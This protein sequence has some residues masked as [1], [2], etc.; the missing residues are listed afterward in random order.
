MVTKEE[1][2]QRKFIDGFNKENTSYKVT[3]AE[4][5][6]FSEKKRKLAMEINKIVLTY[7][8]EH[9]L[10]RNKTYDDIYDK[11]QLSQDI[12]KK[13][14]SGTNRATRQFLY[15]FC[16]GME[17]SR[18]QV[19]ELFALSG[20]GALTDDNIGDYIFVR[21]LGKDSISHFINEYQEY[22][23]KKIAMRVRKDEK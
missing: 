21:A 3:S 19:D 10:S 2:T 15:K 17:L 20:D 6:M 22:T 12:V 8:K 4:M 16:I 9:N 5:K 18:P 14:I 13:V 11:C 7:E 1:M 23:E